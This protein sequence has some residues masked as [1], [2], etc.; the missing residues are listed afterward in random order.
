VIVQFAFKYNEQIDML[1]FDVQSTL[2]ITA[3]LGA[4]HFAVILNVVISI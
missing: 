4:R 2:V 3:K 1:M